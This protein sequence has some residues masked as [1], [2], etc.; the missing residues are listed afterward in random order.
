M[1]II[2]FAVTGFLILSYVRED[3]RFEKNIFLYGT[4]AITFFIYSFIVFDAAFKRCSKTLWNA[5]LF[6][7][8]VSFVVLTRLTPA[9]ALKQIAWAALA[10]TLSP[11]VPILLNSKK[12]DFTKLKLF[13]LISGL[14]L[15]VSVFIYGSIT[16]GAL[17]WIDFNFTVGSRE[18]SF[19]FQPSEIVKILFAFFLAASFSSPIRGILSIAG[20]AGAA[21]VFVMI[22]VIQRDLGGALLFFMV[23]MSALYVATGSARLFFA[24]IIAAALAGSF[25]YFQFDHVRIRVVSFLNPW[26]D[27]FN[28]GN[29]IMHSLFAIYTNGFWGSGL[30]LGKPLRI[31]VVETDFIFAAAS[32]EFGLIFGVLIIVIYMFILFF[33]ARAALRAGDDF[34]KILL[35]ALVSGFAFQTF[36]II[37]GVI[38]LIPL[39]GVTTPFLSYGGTS[40]LTSLIIIAVVQ[41]Y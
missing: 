14:I 5:V 34:K 3:I 24:G 11:V 31:P 25:A 2:L 38:K 16:G 19:S 20:E 30:N 23:F 17:N 29:Q 18:I 39:T 8:C 7:L 22:L 13:Y 37:G 4:A 12:I 15:L 27:F 10:V 9:L 40:L 32:E 28:T 26:A 36:L 33:G 21:A 35:A 41:S 1:I 6:L